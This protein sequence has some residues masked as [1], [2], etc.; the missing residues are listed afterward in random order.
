MVE[1]VKPDEKFID[2]KSYH[3]AHLG[4]Q[5]YVRLPLVTAENGL[6][7]YSYNPIGDVRINKE[8]SELLSRQLRFYSFDTLISPEAKA[9]EMAGRIA[10]KLEL[11]GFV[12]IRKGRKAYMIK[13]RPYMVSSITT[14]QPQVFWL[15]EEDVALLKGKKVAVIEDVVSTGGTLNALFEMANQAGF[16]ISLI[17]CAFVEGE[18]RYEFNGVPIV[19]LAHLPL[20]PQ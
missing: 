1:I 6:Q 18:M 4:N 10:E 2:S 7:I 11:P 13:P 9:W 12:G 14:T 17:I 5:L 16:S 19:S 8:V 20:P 15:G 3:I